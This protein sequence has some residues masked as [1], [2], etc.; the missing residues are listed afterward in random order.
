[1]KTKIHKIQFVCSLIIPFLPVLFNKF[2]TLNN[3]TRLLGWPLKFI[4]YRGADFPSHALYLFSPARFIKTQFKMEL[5]IL[6][7]IITF[8]AMLVASK[9]Y[10]LY[11]HPDPNPAIHKNTKKL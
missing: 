6:D 2:Q 9:L 3:S 1:M 11:K 5:Y 10:V 7:V 8:F 4:W